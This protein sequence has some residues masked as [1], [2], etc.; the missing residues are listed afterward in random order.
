MVKVCTLSFPHND[1]RQRDGGGFLAAPLSM[2]PGRGA[3]GENSTCTCLCCSLVYKYFE[4]KNSWGAN[5]APQTRT[6]C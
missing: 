4:L 3:L 2:P 6:T 5:G 1:V